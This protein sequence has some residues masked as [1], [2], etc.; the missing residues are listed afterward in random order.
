MLKV[1]KNKNENNPQ[2]S[3]FGGKVIWAHKSHL[4][5]GLLPPDIEFPG[6]GFTIYFVA[7]VHPKGHTVGLRIQLMSGARL[8][9]EQSWVPL[10]SMLEC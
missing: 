8:Y 9:C 6:A 4:W 10:L 5:S 1:R 7:W 3:L 2:S